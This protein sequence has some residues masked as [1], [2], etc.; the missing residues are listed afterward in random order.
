M[1]FSAFPP[2]YPFP[3]EMS[4]PVLLYH[5]PFLFPSIPI[6]VILRLPSCLPFPHVNA[7]PPVYFLSHLISFYPNQCYS[8]PT[9]SPSICQCHS[10]SIISLSHLIS[11]YPNQ[12][13]SQ[14]FL[15]STVSPLICQCHSS[16]IIFLSDLIYL[17]ISSHP[18]PHW[19][20]LCTFFPCQ[21]PYLYV[22][23]N[24]IYLGPF[25]PSLFLSTHLSP[26]TDM[27]SPTSF[28]FRFPITMIF[29]IY[30]S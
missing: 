8:Q 28:P 18:F 14:T 22:I 2:V 24:L 10:F 11:F 7:I 23:L 3:V 1:L 21:F 30:Q 29:L 26:S 12:C 16:S 27:S 15:L 19:H 13:H 25:H 20:V 9:L 6:N 4:M 17:S 5:L